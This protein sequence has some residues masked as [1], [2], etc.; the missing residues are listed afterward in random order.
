VPASKSIINV[1]KEEAICGITTSSEQ[2][3]C[4]TCLTGVLSG[5]PD[6]RDAFLS[7]AERSAGQKMLPCVSRAK[8][9]R[10]VL[11]L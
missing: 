6:H 5:I 1:L 10:L 8:S 2:G 11:D 4:E 9:E 7:D 3:V